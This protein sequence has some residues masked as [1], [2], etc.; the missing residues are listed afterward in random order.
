M[1][2]DLEYVQ[3]S[4]ISIV[5]FEVNNNIQTPSSFIL[6]YSPDTRLVT[7]GKEYSIQLKTK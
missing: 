5:Q 3:L 1:G 7:A 2:T 6:I 4:L